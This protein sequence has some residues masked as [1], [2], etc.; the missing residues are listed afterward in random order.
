MDVCVC[1]CC[2]ADVYFVQL[3]VKYSTRFAL[4][5]L[6]HWWGTDYAKSNDAVCAWETAFSTREQVLAKHKHV[7]E[8]WMHALDNSFKTV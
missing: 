5:H 8:Q 2:L 1:V 6:A 7:M 3:F 4:D